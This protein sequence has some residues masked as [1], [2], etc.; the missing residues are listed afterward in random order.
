MISKVIKRR[1]LKGFTFRD[2][3]GNLD[4]RIYKTV[5]AAQ[6]GAAFASKRPYSHISMPE[7]WNRAYRQGFRVLSAKLLGGEA[8]Y[9]WADP[10]EE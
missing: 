5:E 3:G 10:A 9:K 8:H 1:I 2:P 4:W 7:D 6:S